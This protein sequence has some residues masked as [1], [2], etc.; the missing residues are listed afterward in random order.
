MTIEA[1]TDDLDDLDSYALGLQKGASTPGGRNP[2][3][4]GQL[5]Q[6]SGDE[7]ALEEELEF[8]DTT[9]EPE[10]LT[11]TLELDG[12]EPPRLRGLLE[13]VQECIQQQNEELDQLLP[14]ALSLEPALTLVRVP[15]GTWMASP[16]WGF[17]PV[18]G[19]R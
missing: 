6:P 5:A 9:S 2:L 17:R 4:L 12:L 11:L 8:K 14:A 13:E 15:A 19:L 7:L 10:R 18:R 1:P 16:V 3:L